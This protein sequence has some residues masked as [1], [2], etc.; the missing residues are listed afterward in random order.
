M[1]SLVICTFPAPASCSMTSSA[2]R[3]LRSVSSMRVPAGTRRRMRSSG[4]LASGKISVPMRGK[5][6]VEKSDRDGQIAGNKRPSQPQHDLKITSIERAQPPKQSLAFFNVMRLPHQPGR[7]HRNQTARKQIRRDH[8]EGDRER[9]RNEELLRDAG[10]EERRK[11]HGKNAQH[12]E[13]ARDCG[14]LGRLDD[15]A[16]AGDAGPHLGVNVFDRDRGFVDE[17]A[18]GERQSAER[19]DV[20]RLAGG[21]ESDQR[22][23]TARTEYSGRQSARCASR[24]GRAGPSSPVSSAPSRP[25]AARF[26]MAVET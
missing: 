3:T 4:A 23:Q 24:A 11:K 13:E 9:Q 10:H 15:C 22:P 8:R 26:R 20:D 16:C 1:K 17:N 18:D 19:H 12:R 2:F 7:K 5:E 14:L 6:Y 25:S 21:P